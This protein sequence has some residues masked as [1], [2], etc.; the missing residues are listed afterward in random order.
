VANFTIAIFFKYK[1]NLPN[2]LFIHD[3]RKYLS[4]AHVETSEIASAAK[5]DEDLAAL[6]FTNGMP[7]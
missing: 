4:G 2:M 1:S 5:G 7:G 6:A 3:I